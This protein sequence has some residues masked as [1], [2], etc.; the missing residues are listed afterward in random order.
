M[1]RRSREE[2]AAHSRAQRLKKKLASVSPGSL[3]PRKPV[4]PTQKRIT[5][6]VSPVAPPVSDTRRRRIRLNAPAVCSGCLDKAAEIVRLRAEVERLAARLVAPAAV[7]STNEAETL[8]QRVT[9]AK[10]DRVNSYAKGHVI[11]TARL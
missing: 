11:G 3:S 1:K 7:V 6:P 9:V 4:S 10:V 5:R 8:R 2:N